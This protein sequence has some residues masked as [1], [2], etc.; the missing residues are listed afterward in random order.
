MRD[1]GERKLNPFSSSPPPRQPPNEKTPQL[2]ATT[3][4]ALHY[5]ACTASTLALNAAAGTKRV[6]MPSLDLLLFTLTADASIVSLNLSLM[7][8]PVGY[9]QV[10]K[11]LIIPFVCLV[12][13]FWFGRRFSAGVVASVATV[14]VGVAVVTVT[15]LSPSS[16]SSSS[17]AAAA[18]GG[19]LGT[20]IAAVS[21]VTSGM[22][23]ILC[24]SMQQKHGLTPNELLSNTAPA[25]VGLVE[26]FFFG[27]L[28]TSLLVDRPRSR[29]SSPAASCLCRRSCICSKG[30]RREDAE[31]KQAKRDKKKRKSNSTLNL[32]L[33]PLHL[34]GGGKNTKNSRPSP[35][36]PWA[37]SSTGTS[38]ATGSTPTP[39]RGPL[40]SS[41]SLPVSRPSGSTSRSLPAWGGFRPFLTRFWDIPRRSRC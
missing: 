21:V 38:R 15:D 28:S 6:R 40:L 23:Q 31:E 34:R 39:G 26:F 37:P 16:A 25:Q 18:S 32:F 13:K 33:S 22:Q 36:S 8:N 29:C 1:N 7:L 12:E 3:L 41:P 5:L 4:C 27:F 14:A 19:L 30:T 20:S 11:L 10:A 17:A 35:Y 24:R 9:Y 2:P